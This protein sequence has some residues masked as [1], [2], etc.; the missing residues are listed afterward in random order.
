MSIEVRLDVFYAICGVTVEFA[1]IVHEL[2]YIVTFRR[3]A[4]A[5]G[6]RRCRT[7]APAALPIAEP[8]SASTTSPMSV[9][10]SA[11]PR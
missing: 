1:Q 10:V 3:R 9:L 11:L 8:S 5:E 7:S 6:S 2:A 4:W